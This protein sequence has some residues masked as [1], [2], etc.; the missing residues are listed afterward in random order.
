MI[1]TLSPKQLYKFNLYL[2][3]FLLC[4]HLFGTIGRMQFN[5][6]SLSGLAWWFNLDTEKNIPSIYASLSLLVVSILIYWIAYT[7]KKMALSFLRWGL[8]FLIFLFLSIDEL[9]SLHEKLI[10]P[11]RDLLHTTGLLYY[12]W[13]IPYGIALIILLIG[14]ISFLYRLPKK[15]RVLFIISGL[16]FIIGAIGF[17]MLGSEYDYIHGTRESLTYTL[18]YTCEEVL[19]MLGIATFT[20]ALTSY[21]VE[22]FKLIQLSISH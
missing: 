19:E 22:E 2:I 6:H 9:I 16:L 4:A 21:A 8:L 11:I 18:I 10:L 7:R 1:L 5:C 20:Y 14:Y 17:E 3:L 12:A 13:M 15:T